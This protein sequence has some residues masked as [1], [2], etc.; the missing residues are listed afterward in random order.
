MLSMSFETLQSFVTETIEF[1]SEISE[2]EKSAHVLLDTLSRYFVKQKLTKQYAWCGVE[3]DD[4][5]LPYADF[6]KVVDYAGTIFQ[7]EPPML[8]LDSP[9]YVFGDIHG[10]YNDLIRFSKMLGMYR[11]TH[12]VPSKFLFLGDY[13]DRGRFSIEVVA[14]LFAMKV[15]Y[16]N[17]IFLLKGNHEIGMINSCYK[18]YGRMCLHGSCSAMFGAETGKEVWNHIQRAFDNLPICAVVDEKIFCAHGGLPR[19]LSIKPEIDIVSKIMSIKRPWSLDSPEKLQEC[20]ADEENQM[21]FDILWADPAPKGSVLGKDGFPPN[22]G[23]NKRGPGSCVFGREVIQDFYAKTGFTHIIRA[24]EAVHF[25]IDLKNSGTLL[26][27]FSSSGYK[28]SNNAAAVFI[29]HRK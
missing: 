11:A 4:E 23:P 10:N 13:V 12:V 15:L 22:F 2:V 7:S 8:R 21:V 18:A 16:P 28:A 27:V 3:D 26:T 6:I 14:Y 29:N 1:H 9:I 20:L 19:I 24:H 17:R 25:G 5:L